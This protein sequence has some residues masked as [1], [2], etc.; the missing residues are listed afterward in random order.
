MNRRATVALFILAVL[1]ICWAGW[2]ELEMREARDPC[3]GECE[4]RPPAGDKI[5]PK[6]LARKDTP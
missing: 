6:L 1:A 4:V 3:E 5:V 2:M